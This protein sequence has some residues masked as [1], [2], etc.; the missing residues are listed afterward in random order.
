MAEESEVFV[1]AN[2]NGQEQD[3]GVF[4][5][6]E[7]GTRTLPAGF[8]VAPRFRPLPVDIVFEKDV[9]VT[10]GD[11]VTMYV[12]VFRPAG[13]EKA[14][15]IVAWSPYGK[16][17]GT[18]PKYANLF[19]LLGMDTSGL[20]GLMKFEGPDP[21]FWCAQGYAVC[22]P[23]PRGA[24]NS[25]G[26]ILVWSRREG[27]DYHD[28]I[29]W[30][31]EQEWCTGK[32]GTTGN[33]YL[34]ISQ[35]FAAAAQPPHLA[36]IAPWEG[37]SDIY[38]DLVARGGI[39]DLGFPHMLSR[40]FIGENRREDLAAEAERHPLMD[41]FWETKIP[42]FEN[43]TVPAYVVASYSNSIHTPGTFRGW[44]NIASAEK[45]LRIHNN[46]EWPDYYEEANHA[47]LRRFFD[48]YLKDV[49]NGWE[50]T[51][52]VRYSLMDLAGGDQIGVPAEA[53]P[54]ADFKMAKFYLDESNALVPGEA[55]GPATASYDS[56]SEDGCATFVLRVDTPTQMV[57]YPKLHLWAEAEG[58]DDMD[59]FVFLQKLDVDGRQ[60][61]Q[62]TV[63]NNGPVMQ[64]LTRKGAAILNYKGS[65]GRLRASMRR[66]DEA[67]S[68]DEI[69]VHRFDRVDKLAPG[70]IVE[71]D[72]DLFP[73]G[74]MLYPGEKLRLVVSGYNIV[75]GPMPG[76]PNVPTCN[77]G[78][79]IIH[80]GGDRASYLQIPVCRPEL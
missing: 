24:F 39:P 69:P 79:H 45:W 78:R 28:L 18:A 12:D 46:M 42:L 51:P 67:A 36:A 7:P 68:T 73:V 32:V 43:I 48:H 25:E 17:T 38:R 56:E 71:L 40:S 8:Q 13:T 37:M 20:S 66:L 1:P 59:V 30:L 27:R 14:P 47:D 3:L 41:S 76:V 57:G 77:R 63:P 5:A 2:P 50:D 34:A 15:V 10:L 19:D 9:A 64:E 22:N 26:D 11:G 35:W 23:D 58:N 74:L 54:P 55:R 33:S 60:L 72:I 6:F 75:G 16:S 61:E 62:I 65:N 52:R 4:S 53:F 29:E 44:R 21:A 49:D 31:A 70:E 80:T